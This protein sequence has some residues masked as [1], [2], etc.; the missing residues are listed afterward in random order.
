MS[1]IGLYWHTLR[2][3]KPIQFWYRLWFKFYKPSLPVVPPQELRSAGLNW[4]ACLRNPSMLSATTFNFLNE[5]RALSFPEGWEDTDASALWQYNVH[6]FDDL[7]ADKAASRAY[8]HRDLVQRWV[9]D[10]SEASSIAWQP[11][12]CSLR[13]VNWIKWALS[14]NE[15]NGTV[16]KSLAM[17]AG[18]LEKR[19]EYHLQANHL[20]VNGKAL[21]FAGAFFTSSDSARWLG[22]GLRLL[23]EQMDVQILEDGGHFERSPM[24]HAIILEDII[25]LIQLDTIY[26]E[27]LGSA[28]ISKC[29]EKAGCMQHWLSA[30][31][32]PDG[33]VSF[34]NDSVDSISPKLSSLST[35]ASE[36]DCETKTVNT[37]ATN[38]FE[39]SGYVRLENASAIV[40]AD[41]GALGPDYQLGHAHADTLSFEMCLFKDRFIVNSGIDRYGDS[42]ERL[43]QRGT[44][45]HSTVEINNA[46]SSEVWGGFRV[47]RRAKPFNFSYS[48]SEIN[49]SVS[50]SHDGYAR[51]RGKPIHSRTW[52]LGGQT[53]LI[54]DIIGGDYFAATGRFHLHPNVD[55][56]EVSNTSCRLLHQGV[57]VLLEVQGGN[58]SVVKSSYHPEFGLSIESNCLEIEFSKSS[59]V[60]KFTWN[61]Q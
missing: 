58:I 28:F 57:E 4:N 19:M 26:P 34:F 21:V 49:L 51:L 56:S 44:A 37:S 47:A 13:I 29:H 23:Q 46:N 12:P 52:D 43:R 35:Y 3:L 17:Q 5:E 30:M 39:D 11:Y 20:W 33:G 40:I 38:I 15:I 7:V 45:A 53:L 25:D 32:F 24:Y 10:N 6:Y 36:F 41:V 27:L 61:C 42:D 31:S 59:C 8:F 48:L 60:S 1:M 50:C 54:T 55:V 14:G 2:H 18:F 16:K 22:K 9:A